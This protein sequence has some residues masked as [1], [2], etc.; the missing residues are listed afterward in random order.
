MDP[1]GLCKEK[2]NLLKEISN[3]LLPNALAYDSPL[4]FVNGKIEQGIIK[5]IKEK[6]PSIPDYLLKKV[7][8]VVRV[9][10]T[11]KEFELLKNNSVQVEQKIS[12]FFGILNRA[13]EREE[14][15]VIMKDVS[16]YIDTTKLT[17]G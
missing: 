8:K 1:W 13:K 12:T 14:N 10:M 7:S 16:V 17:G 5:A 3:F 11:E 4:P 9:E 15:K 2:N 6:A